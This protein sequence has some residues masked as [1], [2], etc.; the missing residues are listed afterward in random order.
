MEDG[1]FGECV[2]GATKS[3]S[4]QKLLK[5]QMTF[6]QHT[7][8]STLQYVSITKL[9]SNGRNTRCAIVYDEI[10]L[11]EFDSLCD[12]VIVGTCRT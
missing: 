9:K 12:G 11:E 8:P 5:A 4:G 3:P 2:D 10:V 7:L 6:V 1:H